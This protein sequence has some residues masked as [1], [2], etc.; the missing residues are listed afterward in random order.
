MNTSTAGGYCVESSYIYAYF[1]QQH[2]VSMRWVQLLAGLDA[3]QA[4]A[5]SYHLELGFGQGLG[6]AITAA[7]TDEQQVGVDFMPQQVNSLS[8]LLTQSTV[9]NAQLY[10]TDFAHFLET[11]TQKFQ[12]ISLHGVWSWVND[13]V[14]QQIIAI[15]RQFLTDDGMVYVSHNVLP[16]C[17][18]VLPMQ[19]LIHH[20]AQTLQLSGD[21]ALQAG[22]S[23]LQSLFP[24]STYVHDTPSLQAW[25]RSLA[26]EHPRY[27]AH[28]YLGQAWTP[29]L[30]QDTS[31]LLAQAG[32]VFACSADASEQLHDIH[33]TT[34]QQHWLSAI[35]STSLRE[36]YADV[37]RNQTFRRDIWR[38]QVWQLS[39]EEQTAQLS[40][41]TIVLL[42][43]ISDIVH[44]IQGDL[45]TFALPQPLLNHCLAYLA[46]D[47]YLPKSITQLIDYI[48][49]QEI[50]A[51]SLA[52]LIPLLQAL[53]SLG[54]IH[55]A[56]LS[57]ST[58]AVQ[59]VQALN[60]QLIQMAWQHAHITYL[61]SPVAQSGVRVTRLQQLALQAYLDQQ[62]IDVEVWLPWL[63][64]QA[65]IQQSSVLDDV[66][67]AQLKHEL[68]QFATYRLMLLRRLQVI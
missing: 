57:P 55:P 59:R 60:D 10:C 22:L 33:L 39:T 27:L 32:L 13:D 65:I 23:A 18:S 34:E 61:A 28:E 14:K 51:I 16:G 25:W 2:P 54:A 29:L 48:N 50:E 3:P 49:S 24:L 38:K 67:D 20:T 12:S 8:A 31:E 17:A 1:R 44:D 62:S 52:E 42:H 19:R 66:T 9:T 26:Q 63:R 30:F 6:L 21:V 53:S 35:P 15:I 5:Q 64:Q 40:H 46:S 43:P 45:G 47:D 36:S 11:N 68:S 37:M 58:N 56:C 41:Y 7:S 4:H